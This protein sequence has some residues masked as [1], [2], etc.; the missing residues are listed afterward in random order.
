MNARV[1]AAGPPATR[2]PRMS[3]DLP[4]CDAANR[5]ARRN[6]DNVGVKV[7]CGTGAV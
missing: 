7:I 3:A 4:I 1:D 6:Q 5:A 2:R